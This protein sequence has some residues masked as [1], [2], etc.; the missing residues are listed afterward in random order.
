[1][2]KIEHNTSPALIDLGNAVVQTK[3]LAQVGQP[4]TLQ[5]QRFPIP[6]LAND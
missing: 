4:D 5:G 1:M 3:G 6:G 2:H